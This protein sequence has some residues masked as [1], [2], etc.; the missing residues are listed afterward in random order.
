VPRAGPS[1]ASL[2]L[3]Q[4]AVA[5]QAL[6]ARYRMK[7]TRVPG[8]PCVWWRGAVSARTH[9]LGPGDRLFEGRRVSLQVD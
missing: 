1:D 5:D 3:L 4:A 2:E 8:S 9:R 6:V 7:T